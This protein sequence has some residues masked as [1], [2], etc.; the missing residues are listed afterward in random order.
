MSLVDNHPA[1]QPLEG[2]NPMTAKVDFMIICVCVIVAAIATLMYIAPI[3]WDAAGH[4]Q[5]RLNTIYHVDI[6]TR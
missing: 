2:S 1:A 6:T 4:V 3:M 5:D